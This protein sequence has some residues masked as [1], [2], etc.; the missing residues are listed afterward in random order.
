MDSYDVMTHRR[1]YKESFEK[2]YVIE[3]LK[4]CAGGQFDPVLVEEFIK[5]LEEESY[6]ESKKRG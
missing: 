2:G 4:R 3:E 1:V 6:N 5:L